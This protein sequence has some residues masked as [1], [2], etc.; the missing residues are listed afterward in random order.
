VAHGRI[1]VGQ[2]GAAHGLKGEVRLTSFTDDPLAIAGYGPL[3]TE[4]DAKRLTIQNVRRSKA[5]LIVRFQE[6][7]SRS[8]AETLKGCKLYVSRAQ[9]PELEPGVYYH[10]DLVGLM[11]RAGQKRLGRVAQVV[12]F[13][14]GDLLEV[15]REGGDRLLV[16]FAGAM[17]D[18]AMGEIAVELAEGFLEDG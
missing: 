11:V 6:V 4:G 15:E 2:I 17:V 8:E 5:A 12:N 1:L 7:K 18:Q 10:A 13:G 9:L 14:G 3:Q 16:P